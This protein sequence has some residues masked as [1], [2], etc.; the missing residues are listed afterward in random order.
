MA[1]QLNP[2]ISFRDTAGPAMEFYQ[3][4]LGGELTR[5]TFAELDMGTGPDEAHKIMHA[6]LEVPGGLVLMAADLPNSMDLPPN[7]NVSISLSGD[8][9]AELR[10]YFEGLSAGGAVSMPFELAPWGD[11]FGML[12]DP[13]GVAWMVNSVDRR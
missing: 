12:V 7:G 1:N 9:E 6:Q 8:D 10:G 3:S 5:T 13:Y 4:V 2:Y 11:V